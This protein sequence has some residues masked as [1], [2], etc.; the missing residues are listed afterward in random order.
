MLA[1]SH[2]LKIVVF[3]C[4]TLQH[5][6]TNAC[7]QVNSCRWV[8]SSSST[9]T[10]LSISMTRWNRDLSKSNFL[11]RHYR[12]V[13]RELTTVVFAANCHPSVIQTADIPQSFDNAKIPL[14][15]FSY[16]DD[17]PA[18]NLSVCCSTPV[19]IYHGCFQYCETSLQAWDFW[20]CILAHTN[21]SGNHVVDASCNPIV[22]SI[23]SGGRTNGGWKAAAL[24]ALLISYL[25]SS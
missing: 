11:Y 16:P 6:S 25:L 9:T 3:P 17:I 18:A 19:K 21:I 20:D 12:T 22:P 10:D 4:I 2:R 15:G 23:S 7:R 24:S 13:H 8:A 14:C 1:A 5:H